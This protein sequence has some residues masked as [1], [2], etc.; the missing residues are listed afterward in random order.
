MFPLHGIKVIE[1]SRILAGPYCA[2]ILADLGADVLKVEPPEGDD[3][4]TWG[5]PFFAGTSAYFLGA[6]RGKKFVR[7][8]LTNITDREKLFKLLETADVF[9]ENSR[10]GGLKKWGLDEASLRVRFPKLIYSS[11][12]AFGEGSPRASE[13]GYDALIQALGG[14]MSITGHSQPTKIGV[15]LTDIMTALYSCIG[16]LA[17]LRERDTSGLGQKIEVSL[18]D[19]QIASLANVA[20]NFLVSGE[21]PERHGNH[22]PSIVPYGTFACADRELMIAIGNDKQFVRFCE[23][24]EASWHTDK[25]FATNP[26]RVKNRGELGLAIQARLQK[27]SVKEWCERLMAEDIACGPV[28]DLADLKSDAHVI[29][30]DT[31]TT[32]SDGKTPTIRSPLRFSR[33]PVKL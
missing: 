17:A 10:I 23:V 21:I 12:A 25:K 20:M 28:Q 30:R 22:H 1:L 32:L 2:Q 6:N 13:P 26:E 15:A 16:I 14:M 9:I 18:M 19:T 29:A 24:L 8:D 7:L 27:K 5:P 4:R 3:T 33:T 11:I 31:F